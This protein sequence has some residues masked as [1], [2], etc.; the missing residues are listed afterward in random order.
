MANLLGFLKAIFFS[1]W[2]GGGGGGVHIAVYGHLIS[3]P[4]SNHFLITIESDLGLSSYTRF[5]TMSLT[6]HSFS[7]EMGQWWRSY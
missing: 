7:R 3:R 6:N 1:G 4:T 5:E 2:G